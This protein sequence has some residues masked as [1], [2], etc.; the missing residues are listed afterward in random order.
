MILGRSNNI[1]RKTK[2]ILLQNTP[3]KEEIRSHIKYNDRLFLKN[4]TNSGIKDF[5]AKIGKGAKK[6]WNKVKKPLGKVWNFFA[7]E[8]SLGNKLLN[9]IPKAG[10]IISSA[11]S[12]ID[13][14]IDTGVDIAKDI[15]K[16]S[17]QIKENIS[18]P[19]AKLLDNV[20]V[21]KLKQDFDWVKDKTKDVYDKVKDR[22]SEKQKASAIEAAGMLNLELMRNMKPLQRGKL[23]R[24]LPYAPYI[25][26][27]K[28]S[29]VTIP[30]F[31][32]DLDKD[33]PKTIDNTGGRLFLK[34]YA[35][36]INLN[37]SGRVSLSGS[38]SLTEPQSGRI[39]M[40]GNQSGQC[41]KKVE[42]K[43]GELSK[44]EIYK[45]LFG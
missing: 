43:S 4:R 22:L 28:H 34:G 2:H 24:V 5:F 31:I 21:D 9:V 33:A 10:P 32:R 6:V 30:K 17:K 26:I 40:A 45:K 25:D 37:D 38:V 44:E 39:S 35:S 3:T 7:E 20:D 36:G 19:D 14:V 23:K 16:N 13:N 41:N 15:K 18:K 11:I 12:T 42:K 1:Q 8:N 29:R 27:N